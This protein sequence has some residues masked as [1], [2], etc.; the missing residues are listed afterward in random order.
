MLIAIRNKYRLRMQVW[1]RL[2]RGSMK[3][4]DK[5]RYLREVE[6]QLR[7]LGRAMTQGE[8]VRAMREEMG[9]RGR[10]ARAIFRRSRA[11]RGRT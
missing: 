8:L 3:L 4:S 1:A 5:I 2:D 10:L 7:G 9:S 11:E 6:G